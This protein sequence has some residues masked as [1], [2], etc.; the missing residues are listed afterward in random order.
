MKKMN[1]HTQPTLIDI[2]LH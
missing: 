2:H 1:E